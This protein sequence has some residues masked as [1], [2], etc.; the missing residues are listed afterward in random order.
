MKTLPILL[1]VGVYAAVKLLPVVDPSFYGANTT[2]GMKASVADALGAKSGIPS[3][4]I[5]ASAALAAYWL[6]R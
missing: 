1:G 4:A 2:G 5:A 6:A 3:I